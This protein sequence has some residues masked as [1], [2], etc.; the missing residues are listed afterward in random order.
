MNRAIK[1]DRKTVSIV[2]LAVLVL[3]LV[4]YFVIPS[5]STQYKNRRSAQ[6][7]SQYLGMP[8]SNATERLHALRYLSLGL[9]AVDGSSLHYNQSFADQATACSFAHSWVNQALWGPD[10]WDFSN[11]NEVA[12]WNYLMLE[13]DKQLNCIEQTNDNYFQLD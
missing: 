4:V 9:H 1:I 12:A 2:I 13:V 3:F 5:I 11:S 10:A 8:K 6:V 7:Y